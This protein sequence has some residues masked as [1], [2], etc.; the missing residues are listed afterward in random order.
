MRISKLL[1]IGLLTAFGLSAIAQV[2][3]A[4]PILKFANSTDAKINMAFMATGLDPHE[5]YTLEYAGLARTKSFTT[6][7]CGF[8]KITP[9][10]SLPIGSTITIYGSGPVQGSQ[11]VASI[12]VAVAPKCVAGALVGTTPDISKTSEGVIYVANVSPFLKVD[13]GYPNLL[14]TRKVKSNACGQI[15]A[16]PSGRFVPDGLVTLKQGNTTIGSIDSTVVG[17]YFPSASSLNP[18][19]KCTSGMSYL[20]QGWGI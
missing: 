8:F 10:T 17:N 19:P 14:L 13:V 2:A 6:N 12:P 4:D 7:D 1:S 9:S 18:A 3:S 20:P 15:V 11:T 16:K 5:D